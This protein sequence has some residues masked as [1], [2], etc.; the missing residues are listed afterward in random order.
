MIWYNMFQTLV[1]AERIYT[2][3]PGTHYTIIIQFKKMRILRTC[4]GERETRFVMWPGCSNLFWELTIFQHWKQYFSICFKP[5]KAVCPKIAAE[6]GFCCIDEITVFNV[7][8][9]WAEWCIETCQPFSF[10]VPTP[11]FDSLHLLCTHCRI[12]VRWFWK[13]TAD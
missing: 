8:Y 11:G 1:H 12:P 6:K 2:H 10:V 7:T 13:K 5:N 4:L 9:F 3:N